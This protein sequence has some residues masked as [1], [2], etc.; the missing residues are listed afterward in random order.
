MRPH[1]SLRS[2]IYLEA[3]ARESAIGERSVF[4]SP[5]QLLEEPA[6]VR[7]YQRLVPEMDAAAFDERRSRGLIADLASEFDRQAAAEA[8]CG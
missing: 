1:H 8:G 4:G 3:E 5:F 2:L 7:D 6:Y